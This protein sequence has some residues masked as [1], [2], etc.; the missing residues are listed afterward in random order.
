MSTPTRWR[1]PTAAGDP[2]IVELSPM[3]GN[4][5]ISLCEGK[6]NRAIAADWGIAEDTVK[7]HIKRLFRVLGAHDRLH[8]VVLVFT[9]AVDVRVKAPT[10]RWGPAEESLS[11]P[12]GVATA[13]ADLL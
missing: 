13:V 9:G 3:L 6:G 1:P 5:L 10:G 2:C 8:A 7:T 11:L 4:V 12:A